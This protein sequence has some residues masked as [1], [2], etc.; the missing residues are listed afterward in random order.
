MSVFDTDVF[1]IEYNNV[2]PDEALNDSGI[3]RR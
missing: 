3:I 1:S 2:F